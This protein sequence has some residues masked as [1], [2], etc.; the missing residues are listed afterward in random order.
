M[1]M[2][3]RIR[4][5]SGVAIF[6]IAFAIIAFILADLFGQGGFNLLGGTDRSVGA[7]NGKSIK[8]ESFESKINELTGGQS[9]AEN[10]LQNIREQA[11]NNLVFE[12]MYLPEFEKL[13]IDVTEK[14]VNQMMFGDSIYVNARIRQIFSDP[15]TKKF[16]KSLVASRM[17][18]VMSKGSPEEKMAWKKFIASLKQERMNEKYTNLFQ[19]S[20]YITKAEAE[21]EYQAQQTKAEAKFVH[22]PF[23]TIVDSTLKVTDNELQAYLDKNQKKYANQVQEQRS[24]EYVVF[25]AKAST[26]DTT[27]FGKEIRGLAKELALSK[28]DSLFVKNN[29]DNP[30]AIEFKSINQIPSQLFDKNPL[31]LKGGIYGPYVEGKSYK[32]F[33]VVDEKEDS[34]GYTRAGHILFKADDN[35]TAEVKEQ[36]QKQANEI[37]QKIKDGADFAE[38]AK[39]YGTDG[40]K[41]KGGDL[42]W[43]AKGQMV[44]P[45]QDAVFGAKETGLIPTLIKTQFGYHIIKVNNLLTKKKYKLAIVDKVLEPSEKSRDIAFREA[46]Q[47]KKDCNNLTEL[48]E[49]VKKNPKL[50]LGKAEK[51]F[52]AS[53]NLNEI[54]NARPIVRWAFNE[55]KVGNVAEEIFEIKE[56]NKYFI[57]ATSY[58]SKKDVIS[59]DVLRD[60]LKKEVLKEKKT[61]I[62]T[63]KLGD[64]SKETF[65]KIVEKYGKEAIT[66]SASDVVLQNPMLGSTGYNPIAVGKLFGLKPGKRTNAFA[67]EAGVFVIELVKTTPAAAIADYS[68]QKNTLSSTIKQ[69]SGY[70]VMEAIKENANVVDNRYKFY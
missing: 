42:G 23:A 62:I 7:I 64:V 26:A 11:W 56:Q 60:D 38:M 44:A 2:I 55:T 25:E 28:D 18:D 31:I 19:M 48:R 10:Q 65:E 49:K 32:I 52:T 12:E 30:V 6:F 34:I 63:K 33:K 45:F 3:T 37:L 1:S 67:D 15:Q 17:K 57:V 27:E 16:D 22:I 66:N 70:K 8:I 24:V 5:Y 51:L 20:S 58:L 53:A 36:A 9:P 29:S 46:E 61:A 13:G 41:E 4:N 68:Q 35:A 40:T 14:E 69:Q 54:Q 39:Q 59:I 43:F 47:F 21:A 50:V